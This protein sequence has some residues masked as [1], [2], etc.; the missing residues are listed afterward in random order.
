MWSLDDNIF[1]L[2]MFQKMNCQQDIINNYKMMLL[3]M[4]VVLSFNMCKT[5]NSTVSMHQPVKILAYEKEG[6]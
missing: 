6:M 1:L 4:N 5:C 2:C 3:I